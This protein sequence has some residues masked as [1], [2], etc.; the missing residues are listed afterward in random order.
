MWN[1]EAAKVIDHV[2]RNCQCSRSCSEGR[3]G[4]RYPQQTEI[5][6]LQVTYS[7]Y[8]ARKSYSKCLYRKKF[9]K[10]RHKFKERIRESATLYDEEHHAIRL[11]RRLQEQNE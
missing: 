6:V 11:A 2:F 1:I 5:Q 8:Y 7:V 3:R 9:L 10:L 4:Q